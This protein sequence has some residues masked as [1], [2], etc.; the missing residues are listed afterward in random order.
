[1]PPTSTTVHGR[2]SAAARSGHETGAGSTAAGGRNGIRLVSTLGRPGKAYWGVL[3]T[4]SNQ[5]K[6]AHGRLTWSSR[7]RPPDCRRIHRAAGTLLRPAASTSRGQ[8]AASGSSLRQLRALA[9]SS[10]GGSVAHGLKRN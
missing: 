8:G 5:D 2:G 6:G 7:V 1:M 4:R 3:M 10:T 9:P